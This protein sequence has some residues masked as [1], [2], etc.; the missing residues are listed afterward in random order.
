MPEA[1]EITETGTALL[2]LSA[3]LG[4]DQTQS[5][6][7]VLGVSIIL[8]R[9]GARMETV[10]SAMLDRHDARRRQQPA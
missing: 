2:A 6:I 3:L 5:A 4:G 7:T 8:A 10:G 1:E 9:L